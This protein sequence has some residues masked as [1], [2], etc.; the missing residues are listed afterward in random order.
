MRSLGCNCADNDRVKFFDGSRIRG[1]I[2]HF[3]FLD[4]LVSASRI[5][6]V[7]RLPD[8]SNLYER[9]TAQDRLATQFPVFPVTIFG[10]ARRQKHPLRHFLAPGR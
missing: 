10:D 1:R 5:A 6:R 2:S 4:T 9:S 8:K 7:L 3:S